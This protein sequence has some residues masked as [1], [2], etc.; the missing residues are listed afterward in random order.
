MRYTWVS[1][2]RR[3]RAH[4]VPGHTGRVGRGG[5]A[6]RGRA[7][8]IGEPEGPLHRG[9]RA[10]LTGRR[11]VVT[12][13]R[14][15]DGRA[16]V[17][18]CTRARPRGGR[19]PSFEG[20][21]SPEGAY[22]RRVPSAYRPP[23]QRGAALR[24]GMEMRKAMVKGCGASGSHEPRCRGRS[25][26]HWR[27]VRAN[28]CGPSGSAAT[29]AALTQEMITI[30]HAAG[31]VGTLQYVTVDRRVP[32]DLRAGRTLQRE[33]HAAGGPRERLPGPVQ[34]AASASEGR[35]PEHQ[36]RQSEIPVGMV[37]DEQGNCVTP[38][39]PPKDVCPNIKGDQSEIPVG[40]VKDEQ[41]NCV[42]PPPPPKDVC[43]NIK[44]DQ[45]EIP[46]GMVK[47]EQGNCVTPP[48]PPKDVCPNTR[49]TVGDP[50]RDGEGRA[51]QLRHA[52]AASASAS[53]GEDGRVH[54]RAG[55]A[56]TR[57]S[58]CSS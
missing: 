5:E 7:E 11:G 53:D 52:S 42:T 55:G 37:K 48:P 12:S 58:R 13:S 38:P 32:G 24:R 30:C 1:C 20:Q 45:S 9:R 10:E 50:C 44:G 26:G 36:G 4:D 21:P 49:A 29:V 15:A 23:L 31:Q 39:P 47:D 19:N 2:S 3:G 16:C 18:A 6:A 43:P 14:P 22:V 51:G 41:G 8:G 28:R 25:C 17:L 34:P 57:H 35:V 27:D 33:R 56:R 54:G 40:M 46:V